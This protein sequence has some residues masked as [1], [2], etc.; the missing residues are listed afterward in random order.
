MPAN[1]VAFFARLKNGLPVISFFVVVF[2]SLKPGNRAQPRFETLLKEHLIDESLEPP[3]EGVVALS[4]DPGVGAGRPASHEGV[5][6][7][8]RWASA[9]GGWKGEKIS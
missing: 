2:P 6:H 4:D 5:A 3:P 8:A 1:L 9:H 7:G